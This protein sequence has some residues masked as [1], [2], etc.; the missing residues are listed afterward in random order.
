MKQPSNTEPTNK[1][2]KAK[3]QRD[4]MDQK[5]LV[6]WG[7]G[8]IGRGFVADLFYA[9]GYHIVLVDTSATL[10]SQLREA[11]RYT[12]VRAES[13]QQRHDVVIE[14]FAALR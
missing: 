10:I 7:A 14:G 11:G 4:C 5:T 2:E 9:A 3:G 12:V 1:T 8:K 13:A 6:I